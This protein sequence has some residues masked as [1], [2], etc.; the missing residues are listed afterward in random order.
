MLLRV[1]HPVRPG[2]PIL[3]E[4]GS[5]PRILLVGWLVGLVDWLGLFLFLFLNV[6]LFFLH[7][8]FISLIR[9][10]LCCKL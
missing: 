9:T 1:G 7:Y 8:T 3:P 2:Q 5:R 10:D 6:N 4:E